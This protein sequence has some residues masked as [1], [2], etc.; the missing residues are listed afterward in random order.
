MIQTSSQT[1]QHLPCQS[2]ARLALA[3]LTTCYLGGCAS[4]STSSGPYHVD[5]YTPSDPKNVQVFVSL[6]AEMVYVMEGENCLMA[7]PCTIGTSDHPTP[8]GHFQVTEKNPTKRSGE[9]GFWVNGSDAR[10]GGVEQSPGPGYSYIGYPMANWIG[11]APGYGFHE[12]YVWPVPRSHGCIRLHRNA[13]GKLY[14]LVKIGTPVSI[15]QSLPQD[16]TIGKNVV[17]PTDYKDPDPPASVMISPEYF[18]MPR[19][20]TLLPAPPQT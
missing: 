9:Y 20:T 8:V 11:F 6:K 10:P 12:G 19:D 5:A 18:K 3:V 1:E 2:W 7:T 17:H 14:A 15:A 13:E 4:I 16:D